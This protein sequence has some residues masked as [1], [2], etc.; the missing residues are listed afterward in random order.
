MY[1]YCRQADLPIAIARA[2]KTAVLPM[3]NCWRSS[4][5]VPN[6]GERAFMQCIIRI[7][8]HNCCFEL[9]TLNSTAVYTVHVLQA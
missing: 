7:L 5:F 2:L 8:K 6:F 4:H 9:Y 1:L 3:S